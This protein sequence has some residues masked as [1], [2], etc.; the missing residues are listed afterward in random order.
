MRVTLR[1][2]GVDARGLD[3]RLDLRALGVRVVERE[4][5]G[6]ASEPSVHFRDDE[7]PD[8]ESEVRVGEVDVPGGRVAGCC[9][10]R[11]HDAPPVS[12]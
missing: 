8:G 3:V 6:P 11:A 2:V 1:L 10:D 12:V 5:P 4:S 7:M 9:G